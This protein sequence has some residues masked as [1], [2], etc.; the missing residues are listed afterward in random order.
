MV[1]LLSPWAAGATDSLWLCTPHPSF[2]PIFLPPGD[3]PTPSE[4]PGTGKWKRMAGRKEMRESREQ[5]RVQ[6]VQEG[7]CGKAGM[8]EKERQQLPGFL[9]PQAECHHH[10]TGFEQPGH[11]QGDVKRTPCLE[12]W[13]KSHFVN[14]DFGHLD[15]PMGRWFGYLYTERVIRPLTVLNFKSLKN[16]L[17]DSLLIV[18]AYL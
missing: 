14:T 9:Q 5:S 16:F 17:I 18:A 11:S 4:P 6:R 12:P 15:F 10:Q 2:T 3:A 7:E 8:E 1:P 13:C